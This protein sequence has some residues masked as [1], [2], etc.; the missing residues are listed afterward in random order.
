MDKEEA[1]LK[2]KVR[3]AIKPLSRPTGVIG[4]PEVLVDRDSDGEPSIYVLFHV[5]GKARSDQ[6]LRYTRVIEAAANQA[7][8]ALSTYVR[9]TPP[10]P[11]SGGDSP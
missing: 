1:A 2:A 11:R 5:S 4:S 3:E 9:F 7:A 6:L 10:K 8:P